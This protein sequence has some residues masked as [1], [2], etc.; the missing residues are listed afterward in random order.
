MAVSVLASCSSWTSESADAGDFRHWL[1]AT[2]GCLLLYLLARR[3]VTER[4][5]GRMEEDAFGGADMKTLYVTAGKMVYKV[6][7]EIAGLPR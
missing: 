4:T 1:R 3:P 2:A 5:T 6:R 7:T